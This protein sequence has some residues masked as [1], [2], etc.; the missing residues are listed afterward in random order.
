MKIALVAPPFIP[1]P[2]KEYGGTEMFIAQLAEALKVRGLDVVVY[3]NGESTV[4]V[5]KRWIF[6]DSQWPLKKGL[7]PQLRE[8]EHDSWAIA[9]A[10]KTCDVI[11]L[12]S[13]ESLPYTRFVDKPIVYTLHHPQEPALSAFYERYPDIQYVSISDFQRQQEPMRR[14]RTIYHGIDLTHYRLQ[15]TKQQYLSFIGR[16]APVK[17][18][19]TAIA[20]AQRAGIPLKIA[21]EVQPVFREYFEKKIK[22]HV[23]GKFIEYIGLADLD[24]KN[25][26]LGNSLAMLFPIEW[27]E[28]FGLVMVEAM[29][30]GTPVLALAGGS[31]PEIVRDGVSGYLC[32]SMK[33]M[34]T[35]ARELSFVPASIRHYV[36]EHFSLNA[37][38]EGYADLYREIAWAPH[39]RMQVA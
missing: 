19:H 4:G 5:E 27:N 38:A 33:E 20:V 24:A 35:R 1:V 37:M 21:G 31:V 3:A 6:P 15:E 34:A 9:D 25:E 16:I 26:L 29:A 28:P 10:A 17:G 36:E 23:D 13:F 14:N 2:P 7:E 39:D 12:N 22:P 18:T 32:R 30:C 11:H 8:A